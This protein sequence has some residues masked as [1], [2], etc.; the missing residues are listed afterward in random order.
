[1]T[2]DDVDNVDEGSIGEI[3]DP[4]LF[5]I[6]NGGITSIEDRNFVR[7][8]I[9]NERVDERMGAGARAHTHT[10]RYARTHTHTSTGESKAK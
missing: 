3:R 8:R 7:S 4:L 6:Q 1:M 5:S 10:H 2:D 9:I